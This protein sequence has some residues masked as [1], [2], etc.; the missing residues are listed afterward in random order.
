MYPEFSTYKLS[1]EN[2]IDVRQKTEIFNIPIY[3]YHNTGY[4][5]FY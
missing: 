2:A 4:V 1:F 5:K 3:V